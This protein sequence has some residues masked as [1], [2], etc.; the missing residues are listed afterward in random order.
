MNVS[1]LVCC[2]AINFSAVEE[3][4]SLSVDV[5]VVSLERKTSVTDTVD[6]LKRSQVYNGYSVYV[7]V[8]VL[9]S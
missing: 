8:C 6:H 4:L 3:E 2:R 7:C 9:Q 5:V 1:E